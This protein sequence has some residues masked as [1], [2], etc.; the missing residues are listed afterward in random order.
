[1]CK[2]RIIG[3][4]FGRDATPGPRES[5]SSILP[6]HAAR[7]DYAAARCGLRAASA[8]PDV[9][10][11]WLPSYL[12][13]A[14][15]D[16]LDGIRKEI[17]F[18]AV[19]TYL[20]VTD[21]TWITSLDKHD[22][23]VVIAYFG[24][25]PP[26]GLMAALQSTPARILIDAAGCPPSAGSDWGGDAILYSPHKLA[27]V[28]RGGVLLD[29]TGRIEPLAPDGEPAGE[30]AALAEEAFAARTKFDEAGASGEDRGWYR[31]QHLWERKF[32]VGIWSMGRSTRAV[33]EHGLPW[34]EIA[35]R[36]RMNHVSLATWLEPIGLRSLAAASECPLAYVIAFENEAARDAVRQALIATKIYPPIHWLMPPAV[37]KTFAASRDLANQ[38][39]SLPCDQRCSPADMERTATIVVRTL[40]EHRERNEL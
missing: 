30:W 18:Y 36:R 5:L 32:P 13:A 39:L 3:G 37:P 8:H 4:M 25:P 24:V 26:P 2:A 21:R 31:L 19:N 35:V 14:M 20:Q 6:R 33:L 29:V 28:D 9:S 10:R 1:M 40:G 27:G 23:V 11:I 34:A 38:I 22:L 15:I 17:C 12:C 16:G 7:Y